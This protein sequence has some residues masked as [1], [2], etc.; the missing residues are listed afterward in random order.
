[1]TD[2]LRPDHT[3]IAKGPP[4][5]QDRRPFCLGDSLRGRPSDPVSIAIN[6]TL[7]DGMAKAD[8]LAPNR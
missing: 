2:R 6:A 8:D 3:Q 4:V 1:L 5:K 7:I